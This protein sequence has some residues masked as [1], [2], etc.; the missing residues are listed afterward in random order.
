MS[1]ERATYVIED[2]DSGGD[3]EPLTNAVKVESTDE[4]P[5][6]KRENMENKL[7]E[8][9][10]NDITWVK[11]LTHD[12]ACVLFMALINHQH[13]AVVTVIERADEEE[14]RKAMEKQNS[15]RS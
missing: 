6:G 1:E 12:Q 11:A 5:V 13:D 2:D 9:L 15:Q 7:C 8:Y 4:K 10:A 14:A 3:T